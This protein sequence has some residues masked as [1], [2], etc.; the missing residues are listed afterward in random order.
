M[1]T[2]Q[3]PIQPP[4]PRLRLSHNRNKEQQEDQKENYRSNDH[5]QTNHKAAT[6]AAKCDFIGKVPSETVNHSTYKKQ[7][8]HNDQL[9][10]AAAA[11]LNGNDVDNTA[12]QGGG[13]SAV[14]NHRKSGPNVK[15][16]ISRF[17]VA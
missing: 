4:M 6:A 8:A 7:D 9:D 3:V 16:L 5:D 10:G 12:S 15:S 2:T 11:K 1:Q 13:T 14:S 17:S